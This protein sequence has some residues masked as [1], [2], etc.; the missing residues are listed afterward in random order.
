MKGHRWN[1]TKTFGR[2]YVYE[3][4]AA[5]PDLTTTRICQALMVLLD[6]TPMAFD[7]KMAYI[8]SDIPDD[9]QVPVQFE[10]ALRQ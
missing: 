8:N 1:M 3:T 4:Y 2:N 9:E 6:W 10:K 7:I 5:T